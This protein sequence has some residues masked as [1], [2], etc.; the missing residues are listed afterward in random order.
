VVGQKGTL[1]HYQGNSWQRVEL[2]TGED[3]ISAWGTSASDVVVVGGRGTG[4]LSH[5]DGKKWATQVLFDL[6]DINGVWM[7]APGVAHLA[8]AR[9]TLAKWV[10]KDNELKL[11]SFS[12]RLDFHGIF[13]VDNHLTAVGG[14]FQDFGTTEFEGIAYEP[15]LASGE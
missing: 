15:D 4:V 6:S 10:R 3:L 2:E 12:E 13:G 8:A 11:E 1:L 5:Y 14:N 9:G 7:G